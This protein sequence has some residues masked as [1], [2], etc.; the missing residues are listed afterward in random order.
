MVFTI[1]VKIPFLLCYGTKRLVQKWTEISTKVL[2]TLILT[3]NLFAFL[4]FHTTIQR[5][6][7]L[8]TT[9]VHIS[10][11]NWIYFKII[12]KTAYWK[13]CSFLQFFVRKKILI[14]MDRKG[15]GGSR[16]PCILYALNHKYLLKHT[17]WVTIPSQSWWTTK[18]IRCSLRWQG[19]LANSTREVA[20]V[21]YR[22]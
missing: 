8:V 6:Y 14:N 7:K 21:Q 16:H 12:C 10:L 11:Y 1:H 15:G 4:S 17:L 22:K 2:I 13:T 18:P 9:W 19:T 20:C 3:W 5:T